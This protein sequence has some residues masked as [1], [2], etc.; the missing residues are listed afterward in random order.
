MSNLAGYACC[1]AGAAGVA[2]RFGT[3]LLAAMEAKSSDGQTPALVAVALLRG[4]RFVAEALLKC[5]HTAK[6]SAAI[7]GTSAARAK[8]S[9]AD[10]GEF[11]S[12]INLL[13]GK[14]A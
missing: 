5:E 6:A 9:N 8:L 10:N 1:C 4:G 11:L 13:C 14:I 12:T 3:E 7:L 2:V